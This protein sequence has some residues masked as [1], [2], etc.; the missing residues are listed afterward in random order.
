M[1]IELCTV[2]INHF[3]YLSPETCCENYIPFQQTFQTF[4]IIFSIFIH[5]PT[6]IEHKYVELYETSGI[7]NGKYELLM[8]HVFAFARTINFANRKF[9]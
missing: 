1:L 6:N 8:H 2:L 4:T 5:I 3:N 9:N 7:E